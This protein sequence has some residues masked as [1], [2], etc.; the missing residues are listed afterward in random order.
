MPIYYEQKDIN[1]ANGAEA[2]VE[3]VLSPEGAA[4]HIVAIATQVSNDA[5]D[6][7]VNIERDRICDIPTT[8]IDKDTEWL[9]IDHPLPPG[10]RLLVGF[11]NNTG[12]AL[13]A[14]WIAVK[15]IA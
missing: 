9:L 3:I 6:L 5:A 13:T 7:L 4:K 10:V 1:V 11:R 8:G 14:Q 2:Q 12:G 15:Y